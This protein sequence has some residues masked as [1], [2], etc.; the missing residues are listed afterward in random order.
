MASSG[1]HVKQLEAGTASLQA[2]DP[3]DPTN[4]SPCLN[5]AWDSFTPPDQPVELLLNGKRDPI[6]VFNNH[7]ITM[8]TSPANLS[9]KIYDGPGCAGSQI[10]RQA[11]F[12]QIQTNAT[13]QSVQAFDLNHPAYPS[14]CQT[15]AWKIPAI[16]VKLNSW[17]GDHRTYYPGV[18]YQVSYASEDADVTIL[19]RLYLNSFCGTNPWQT[20]VIDLPAATQPMSIY[21]LLRDNPYQQVGWSLEAYDPQSGNV[22]QCYNISQGKMFGSQPA[23]PEAP[24]TVEPSDPTPTTSAAGVTTLPNTGDGPTDTQSATEMLLV[25]SLLLGAM[26]GMLSLTRIQRKRSIFALDAASQK[27]D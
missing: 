23:T 25:V 16:T 1:Y 24:V 21:D 7:L 15:I 26:V 8:E 2:F 6:T 17:W 19:G 4:V 9:L 14:A 5:A 10:V 20:T 27:A 13:T 11:P 18:E 3:A 12:K 22:S